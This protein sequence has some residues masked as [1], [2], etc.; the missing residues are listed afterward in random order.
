MDP[1][2][3]PVKNIGFLVNSS[4]HA[5]RTDESGL[6]YIG[7]LPANR[8]TDIAINKASV[9]DPQLAPMLKGVR[10]VPR[11]GIVTQ[12]DFPRAATGEIDGTVFLADGGRKRGIGNVLVEL[13]DA[14]GRVV[15][16]TRSASDGF[17]VLVELL[18]GDYSLRVGEQQLRDLNL[19][20]P[21]LRKVTMPPEGAFINGQDLTL[22]RT[23][24][25]PES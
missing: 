13:V 14:S 23:P 11:P 2:E 8:N 20:D 10:I 3:Q 7:H 1:D 5:A 16:Q 18:P 9:D 21:G 15:T 19:R 17:F 24:G 6:A 4:N 22:E 12:I 25:E